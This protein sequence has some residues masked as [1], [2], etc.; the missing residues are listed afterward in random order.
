M[1]MVVDH[2]YFDWAFSQLGPFKKAMG[3]LAIASQNWDVS[4]LVSR[5][6]L[7]NV[8]NGNMLRPKKL[9]RYMSEIQLH[10]KPRS[11]ILSKIYFK[12]KDGEKKTWVKTLLTRF[13]IEY[14]SEFD[15]ARRNDSNFASDITSF[16]KGKRLE[17]HVEHPD[18]NIRASAVR[19]MIM[20]ATECYM[21][22]RGVSKKK[23]VKIKAKKN[24]CAP[25]SNRT[26]TLLKPRF[27]DDDEAVLCALLKPSLK[28]LLQIFSSET[29]VRECI[30]VI[31]RKVGVTSTRL[32]LK[33][34]CNLAK[35]KE[36]EKFRKQ[37]CIYY[38]ISFHFLE[39]T[40]I[41][42]YC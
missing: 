34:I 12:Y 18:V 2:I 26:A 17:G 37:V 3:D 7:S 8:L 31:K 38:C 32:A 28:K 33:K 41:A 10:P 39:C 4:N 20:K 36:N 35:K 13:E 14:P 16:L 24:S 23:G 5:I 42:S 30:L 9:F 25:D 15:L 11:E 40:G 27:V 21:K 29:L 6:M 22:G 1:D 19:K